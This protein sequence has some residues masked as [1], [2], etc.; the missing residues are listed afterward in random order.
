L[1][2]VQKEERSV[3]ELILVRHGATGFNLSGRY[4]GRLDPPLAEAGRA[5]ARETAQQ[6][7][8]FLPERVYCSP[9]LRA[10]E[11]AAIIAPDAPAIELPSLR[12]LDF[13]AFEGLAADEIER[14]MPEAWQAYMEDWQHFTFPQ[15]DSVQEYLADAANTIRAIIDEPLSGGVLI[16]SHKGFVTAALSTLLHGDSTH[17]FRYNIRPAGFARLTIAGGFP[18]LTQL[19]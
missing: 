7:A 19:V 4:C 11:T 18:V 8:G 16:V 3:T 9:A 2:F 10:R 12:E 14:R 6:L 15:G 17:L 1:Y 5:A 13:G